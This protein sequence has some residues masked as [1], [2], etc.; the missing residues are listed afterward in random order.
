[1]D[2]AAIQISRT[3]RFML[4]MQCWGSCDESW[5]DSAAK[6]PTERPPPRSDM[7]PTERHASHREACIP[8]RGPLV[9]TCIPYPLAEACIPPR[10]LHPTERTPCRDMHAEQVNLCLHALVCICAAPAPP[11]SPGLAITSQTSWIT[12][13]LAMACHKPIGLPIRLAV[14]PKLVTP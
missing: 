9:E 13:W 2:R 3:S 10:D 1:M 12:P 11:P 6:H 8:P 14:H 7:H 4:R 5:G